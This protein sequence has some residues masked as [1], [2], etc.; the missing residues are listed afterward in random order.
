MELG[1][2]FDI[3]KLTPSF[4][5]IIPC[6]DTDSRLIRSREGLLTIYTKYLTPTA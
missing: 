3:F 4:L 6:D 5:D 1:N 2:L